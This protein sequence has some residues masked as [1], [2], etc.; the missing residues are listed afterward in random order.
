M[1]TNWLLWGFELLLRRL[2]G[3]GAVLGKLRLSASPA[4]CWVGSFGIL[5]F[6]SLP[7]LGCLAQSLTWCCAFAVWGECRSS[8]QRCRFRKFLGWV[9]GCTKKICGD[10]LVSR[11]VD[12]L[13]GRL[14]TLLFSV[15]LDGCKKYRST[16]AV[17][18]QHCFAPYSFRV[19][20]V[21]TSWICHQLSY[22]RIYIL[23]LTIIFQIFVW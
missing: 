2:I 14:W 16:S 4:V 19:S 6:F 15:W 8:F 3:E 22:S 9:H 17:F 1:F 12:P 13:I 20:F 11:I 23:Y 21:P 10:L 5:A 18:L 7:T